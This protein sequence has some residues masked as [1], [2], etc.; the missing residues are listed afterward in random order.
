[1]PSDFIGKRFVDITAA[2]DKEIDAKNAQLV[3][4]GKIDTY[5]MEKTYVFPDGEEVPALLLVARDPIELS[6]GFQLFISQVL[7]LVENTQEA[8]E[9]M[10]QQV[11]KEHILSKQSI[12]QGRKGLVNFA[13]E[14]WKS[15]FLTLVVIGGLIAGIFG[16]LLGLDK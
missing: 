7:P 5:T 4:E 6:Q 12:Q 15:I 1:M 2:K 3:I 14:H 9:S 11:M 16:E 13:I 10:V 8:V